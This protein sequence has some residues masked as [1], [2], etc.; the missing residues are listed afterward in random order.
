M[1]GTHE[2]LT[3]QL[4]EGAF[5]A[6]DPYPLFARLRA[7]APLAW[8]DDPGFLAVSK[9]A[10][11]LAVATDTTTYCSS[12]GILLMEIGTTYDTPPTM[13]HTDPPAHT[14]YRA[15]VSPPLRKRVVEAMDASVRSRAKALVDALPLDETVDVVETLAVPFPI[16][17]IAD[18][19]GLGDAD[20]PRLYEWSEAVI[21][22]ATD[23]SP[24][25]AGELAL[26]MTLYLMDEAAKRRESRGD[27]LISTV[28]LAELD[29]QRL[30]DDEVAMFLIQL[31]VA[32]NETTRNLVS[33][34]LIAFAQQPSEWQR[35]RD[36]AG[37]IPSAT[38]ELL[39]WTSPVSSFMRT[40][41]VDT[42]L[43]GAEISA[44]DHLLLLYGSADRDED[45]FGPTA[46]RLDVGRTPN[47]HVAFGFGA[48]F[49][50]GAA[51]ARLETQVLLGL[52][53]DRIGSF[54]LAGEVVP[55]PSTVIA[56]VKRAP[57][58]L[59]AA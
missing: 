14:A 15:L 48:H 2:P 4:L 53:R 39:R 16:Q 10:D 25:R 47:H 45:T 59:R 57:M 24:E 22:G 54:E 13:M 17:V 6:A 1:P 21:P 58:V 37:L 7:E 26:E 36:D 19:L 5:P 12:R 44:G 55:L 32:G 50:L 40:A 35:L 46:N 8:C 34:G 9:M 18:L 43:G 42:T 33:G 41:T 49:C 51:L 29:G 28:A 31:L 27:D 52:L 20:V 11:V 56:G 3:E 38:E 30:G 23:L